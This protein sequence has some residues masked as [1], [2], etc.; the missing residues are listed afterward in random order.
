M[1]ANVSALLTRA[2]L[3][4]QGKVRDPGHRTHSFSTHS[5]PCFQCEGP[6]PHKWHFFPHS[7]FRRL[8]LHPAYCIHR[9]FLTATSEGERVSHHSEVPPRSG[10]A[11]KSAGPGKVM[12][13]SRKTFFAELSHW[14]R[15]QR[16]FKGGPRGLDGVSTLP[17]CGYAV[18]RWLCLS[19]R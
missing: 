10:W 12:L 1:V 11:V 3:N 5:R 17:A 2:E 6:L 14:S 8:P 4:L 7:A 19:V 15:R 13:I 16:S 18:Q 9:L